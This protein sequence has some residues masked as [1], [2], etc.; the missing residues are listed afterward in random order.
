M[1]KLAHS[2]AA[3]L[4]LMIV[5]PAGAHAAAVQKCGTF[6]GGF[7]DPSSFCQKPPG[8][9]ALIGGEGVCVKVP[10]VCNEIYRPVC[11]CDG[12]TYSNDCHR[13]MA[14]VSKA[15]NGKCRP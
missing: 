2:F 7:C 14:R 15:H 11:G 5:L 10:E 4:V 9:C 12:Q 3:A 6:P 13:E 1:T 8:T